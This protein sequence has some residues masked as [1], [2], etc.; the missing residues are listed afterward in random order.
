MYERNFELDE[1]TKTVAVP[2]LDSDPL[3][4]RH[5]PCPEG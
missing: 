3:A 2:D 4:N 1:C 5:E